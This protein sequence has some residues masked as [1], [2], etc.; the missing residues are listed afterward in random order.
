MI[1]IVAFFALVISSMGYLSISNFAKSIA[2]KNSALILSRVMPNAASL[3]TLYTQIVAPERL[4]QSPRLQAL[5]KDMPLIGPVALLLNQAGVK[6]TVATFL[7]ATGALSL[8]CG[9]AA[10]V[11]GCNAAAAGFTGLVAAGLPTF[12]FL[13]AR[14]KRVAA[15]EAQLVQ[16]LEMMTL[17]LRSGRSLPQAFV[18]T[19]EE[20]ESPAREELGLCSEEYRLGRPLPQALRGLSGKYPEL[21]GLKL[22]SI[23]VSVIGQTGGNLVEVLDRIRHTLE[24]S[25]IY[26]LK[27]RSMT[28]ESRNTATLLGATPGF[29]LLASA[30]LNPSYFN[31]FFETAMGVVA[32][33][34]FLFLWFAGLLWLRVLMSSK[35][36]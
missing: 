31:M 34:I 22:L 10:Y 35:A 20:A 15:F 2:A 18:A 28:G 13:R 26:V 14:A 5:L 7:A 36:T 21:M 4:A 8:G 24:A 1:A 23:A 33:C 32:F 27:L 6:T 16:I 30:F 12:Y 25:M 17:Y 11:L 9:A 3:D 19:A 29:S